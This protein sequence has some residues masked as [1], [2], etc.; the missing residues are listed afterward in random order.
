MGCCRGPGDVCVTVLG[1]EVPSSSSESQVQKGAA[2]IHSGAPA[3]PQIHPTAHPT[4]L[5]GEGG[6]DVWC[7]NRGHWRGI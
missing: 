5:W 2:S 7:R 1:S 4:T 3:P 6:E